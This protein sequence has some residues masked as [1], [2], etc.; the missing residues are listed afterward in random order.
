MS[1]SV[2]VSVPMSVVRVAIGFSCYVL[3]VA[4][5][6]RSDRNITHP[7][8]RIRRNLLVQLKHTGRLDRHLSYQCHC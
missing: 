5:H 4:S 1:M 8:E 2:S 6:W 7:M 3:A